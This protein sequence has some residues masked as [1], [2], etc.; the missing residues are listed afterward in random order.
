MNI[1]FLIEKTNKNY[2]SYLDT[3]S[4][5]KTDEIFIKSEELDQIL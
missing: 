1:L 5:F 2:P 4:K 3:L